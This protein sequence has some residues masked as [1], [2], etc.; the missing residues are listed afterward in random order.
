M[1]NSSFQKNIPLTTKNGQTT[2]TLG[3][4]DSQ[5]TK[6]SAS[7]K[8]DDNYKAEASAGNTQIKSG[9]IS[10]NNNGISANG[11]YENQYDA[12][13]NVQLNHLKV[14]AKA[15]AS[16]STYGGGSVQVKDGQVNANVNVGKEYKA[17]ANVNIN[18]N[19]IASIDASAKGEANAN[20]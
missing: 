6:Y 12:Q 2:S 1:I 3:I 15:S 14:E 20:V 10:L 16:D 8:I 13:A 5:G 11:R 7:A 17:N 19:N 9:Q 18:G 4:S